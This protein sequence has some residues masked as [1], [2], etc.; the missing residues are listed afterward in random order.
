MWVYSCTPATTLDSRHESLSRFVQQS[1]SYEVLVIGCAAFSKSGFH[2][3]SANALH[4]LHCFY[5]ERGQSVAFSAELACDA[6]REWLANQSALDLMDVP[7]PLS[8]VRFGPVRKA[9]GSSLEQIAKD[10]MGVLSSLY[11]AQ[12]DQE[13][14][15]KGH[16]MAA[17]SSPPQFEEQLPQLVLR[18]VTSNRIDASRFFS[19]KILSG[20]PRRSRA[21]HKLDIDFKGKRLVAN[22]AQLR[23]GRLSAQVG[24]IKQKLWDL[25]IDRENDFHE[26]EGR[27]HELLLQVPRP[28]AR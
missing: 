9:E 6:I 25:K 23:P 2:L 14:S 24:L 20:Q 17:A 16:L 11:D 22:I 18:Y 1:R 27:L 10:W 8:G 21:A 26:G 7:M 13:V 4:R 12:S 19:E 28:Q 3:E 5:G 15:T